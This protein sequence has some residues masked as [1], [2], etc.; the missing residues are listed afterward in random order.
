ME[1][2]DHGIVLGERRH[3]ESG[4]IVTLLTAEHGRHAG[5][6]RSTQGPRTRGVFVPGNLVSATWRARL[7]EHLGTYTA[8]LVTPYAARVLEDPGRL[9]ALAAAC[10]LIDVA[11]PEREPHPRAFA[12]LHDLMADALAP[13]W[14]AAYVRWELDLL[15]ELG[16][17]L[18]LRC[19]AVTGTTEDLGFV[20][21]RTGRAV[22]RSAAVPWQGRLLA[23]PDFLIDPAA[24]PSAAALR[25]GLKLTGH[26]LVTHLFAPHGRAEPASRVRLLERI[27]RLATISGRGETE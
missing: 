12:R 2:R 6:V 25:A 15:A 16:F 13:G 24:E 9:A 23:L 26:F 19:C 17:G 7:D 14:A 27:D 5:R 21:P 4:A 10:A 18:D 11:L 22:S 20:S 8:E 3:G 1:W